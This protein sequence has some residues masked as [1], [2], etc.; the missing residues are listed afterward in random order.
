MRVLAALL[1]VTC[2]AG[3]NA[4]VYQMNFTASSFADVAGSEPVPVG[5]VAGQFSWTSAGP[6]A[7][8]DALVGVSLTIGSHVYSLGELG[9]ENGGGSTSSIGGLAGGGPNFITAGTDDFVITFDRTGQFYNFIYTVPGAT[10]SWIS[11]EGSVQ[12]TG[13]SLVPEP[14]PITLLA[15]SAFV[16]LV[17]SSRRR[18]LG[19][20]RRATVPL[21]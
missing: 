3:A 15:A 21:R 10:T 18:N 9:F 16:V 14:A 1:M 19:A 12:I 5:S 4:A 20:A 8:L 7:T 13:A 17:Q 6:G 2:M 11:R